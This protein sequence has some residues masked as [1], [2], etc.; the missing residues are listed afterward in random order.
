MGA[1]YFTLV[2]WYGIIFLF[3]EVIIWQKHLVHRVTEK[4]PH[5]VQRRPAKVK[6]YFQ[7]LEIK[8]EEQTVLLPLSGIVRSIVVRGG[9]N[10]G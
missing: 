1:F 10:E 9:D 7:K 4:L 3:E 5:T 6:V 2:G 8:V